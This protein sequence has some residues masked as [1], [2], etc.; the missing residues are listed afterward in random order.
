MSNRANDYARISPQAKAD[1][2]LDDREQAPVNWSSYATT[3]RVALQIGTRI[4][5]GHGTIALI[6][7]V[8]SVILLTATAPA[9]SMIWDEPNYIVASEARINWLKQ[10]P[11]NPI[12]AFSDQGIKDGWDPTH[13]HPP[14]DIVWTGLVRAAARPFFDDLTAYRLGNI[15]LVGAFVA[16]LYYVMASEYGWV[17]GLASVAALLAMP[18]F[19][20]HAHVDALDVPVTVAMFAVVFL[21]WRTYKL[22][23]YRWTILLGLVL[24]VALGTKVNTI[25][26]LPILF[27]W[28]LFFHT[29][30]YLF[31][32]LFLMGCIAVPIFFLL[33]PWLYHD[34]LARLKELYAFTATRP[35]EVGQI[36][37]HQVLNP[38]PWYFS[39]VMIVAVT[40]LA[41]TLLSLAGMM[42][43]IRRQKP[44]GWLF[45]LTIVI[46][47]A[48]LV[49][50]KTG[51]FDNDRRLVPLFPNVAALAGIGFSWIVESVRRVMRRT[52]R[53]RWATPLS[54]AAAAVV[55]VPP[56]ASS[57]KLFPY[58][59]S[60]YSIVVGGLPG[61]TALG[62]ESTYWAQTYATAL[63]YL[64]AHAKPGDVVWVEPWTHEILLY[65]QSQ[66][67]LRSDL[68]IALHPDTWS[69]MD[70]KGLKTYGGRIEDA[71]WAVIQYRQSGFGPDIKQVVENQTP[72]YRL[73]YSGTPLMDIYHLVSQRH[74]R[75]FMIPTPSSTPVGI[76]ADPNG[77][78]WFTENA[79][80]KIARITPGGTITEFDIPTPGSQPWGITPGPDGN[81]WFTE[82]TGNKI[83]RITQE[84]TIAEFAV[85]TLGSE[86]RGIVA[87][88]DGNLWFPETAGN[89]IGRITPSGNITEFPVPTAEAG[90]Y[91]ITL[92]PDGNLWFAELSAAKIG[93]I[94]P[95]GAIAEFAVP[96]PNSQPRSIV[97]GADGNLW[98]TEVTGN[99]IG[100]IT[101]SGN[102]TEFTVP[103][104]GSEPRGIT[105]AADG[106][107][108]FEERL[109]NKIGRISPTGNITEFVIPTTGSEP[110]GITSGSDSTLWFTESTGNKLGRIRLADLP[111]NA[112]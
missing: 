81:L 42:H 30:R 11:S 54:F 76:V 98:F 80:N 55:F 97:A 104:K 67:K 13:E 26:V 24:G 60:Y 88:A 59:L 33:W 72:S 37:F 14:V 53:V 111:G 3:P 27:V 112:Q 49:V 2:L 4:R 6:L 18:R 86:P 99:K 66:G 34:T 68:R 89:K 47:I 41:L 79:G 74:T 93:R 62:F 23:G 56:A 96:T 31:V 102:I 21:Y 94:T 38:P 45:I 75:E 43:T 83:G 61:A 77:N 1:V 20:F 109:G 100:R 32:R 106:N 17:A 58:L 92:G 50:S 91:G 15:L 85:P 87:G 90:P 70:P 40:P 51:F 36:F 57:I 69:F 63:P 110:R 8:L 16:A 28:T 105:A 64:N 7:G 39:I 48:S 9:I 101:T 5:L 103:T 84:G 65:Y 35:R 52:G 73:S 107:L 29:R 19:F 44:L 71:D 108:Y 25:F 78:I 10:I 22:P 95:T 46:T 12:Y 82:M